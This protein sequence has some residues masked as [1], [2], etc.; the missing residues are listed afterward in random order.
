MRNL[1][2]VSNLKK[3]EDYY[4]MEEATMVPA[5]TARRRIRNDFFQLPN[6]DLTK[7]KAKGQKLCLSIPTKT[8]P[9]HTTPHPT[10]H[11]KLNLRL[12]LIRS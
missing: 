8:A 10:T 2:S 5:R 12:L 3:M 9:H 4:L 1:V 11:R 6:F 7:R